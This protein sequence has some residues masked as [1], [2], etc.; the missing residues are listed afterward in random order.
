[1]GYLR[2]ASALDG[3]H[4][5]ERRL[6]ERLAALPEPFG[7]L[8]SAAWREIQ[9]T[10]DLSLL[11][12]AAFE[13][14]ISQLS[15][16]VVEAPLWQ[17]VIDLWLEILTNMEKAQVSAQIWISAIESRP[18]DRIGLGELSG[19]IR[20]ERAIFAAHALKDPSC[21]SYPVVLY[22]QYSRVMRRY[23]FSYFLSSSGLQSYGYGGSG[24]E[25]G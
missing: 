12:A 13:D 19:I 16:S 10:T 1:V 9:S 11:S 3:S 17:R 5:A 4:S 2:G 22:E 14:R 20:Y 7:S 18:D 23:A 6:A 25:A 15:P 24:L 21:L 8:V